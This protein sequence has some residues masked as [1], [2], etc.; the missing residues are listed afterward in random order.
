M[1]A[2]EDRGLLDT[3][4]W[5]SAG[6][7]AFGHS[8]AAVM[9]RESSPLSRVLWFIADTRHSWVIIFFVLS[10]YLVGGKML[11]RADRFD[12][13]AYAIARFAR[14]YVVLLPAL[15][16][17]A[18][19][20]GAAHILAPHSP[21][22][23]GD[24]ANG[25]FGDVPPFARYGLHEVMASLLSLE[26]AIGAP[27]GSDGP[28]W[29]LGFEWMFYFA[30]PALVLLA[31]AVARLTGLPR[32]A[33]RSVLL[34][35]SVALLA[36]RHMPYAGLLWLIWMGGAVAHVLVEQ[37]RSITL[38]RWLGGRLC[39]I[40]FALTLKLDH[41]YTDAVIGLGFVMFLSLYPVGERGW[42][43]RLDHRLSAA[44][45]SLY[46]IHLPL[47][48]FLCMALNNH[49]LLPLGGL[50]LGPTSLG[51]LAGLGLVVAAAT[52]A[53]YLTFER[54]TVAVRKA[55]SQWLGAKPAAA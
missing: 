11:L 50:P 6:M 26:N 8:W 19:L 42:A 35:G 53:F 32:P 51:L 46:L 18:L 22:Y 9:A 17:T 16:L 23:A 44:S 21:I 4:R 40:G 34:A 38:I 2:R 7:V 13:K 36:A 54:H 33:C 12:F 39:V 25:L 41:H 15:A 20:D 48:A 3:A 55:L 37:D 5:I 52:A 14:I 24:W 43:P 47:I 28:L 30:F 31:D 45:Y 49:G 27:M 10:G 1:S 29:S